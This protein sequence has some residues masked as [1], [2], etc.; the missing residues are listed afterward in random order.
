MQTT[1]PAPDPAPQ[2][3]GNAGA[4]TGAAVVMTTT[5]R[6]VAMASYPSYNPTV[7]TG[8]I[9]QAQFDTCSARPTASRS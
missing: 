8:G 5:G 4:T 6:V 7:W 1:W 9:S 2:Q 3:K